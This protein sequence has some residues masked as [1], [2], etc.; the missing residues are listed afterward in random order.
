MNCIRLYP[1]EPATAGYPNSEIEVGVELSYMWK[2]PRCTWN[3]FLGSS[4]L[5][6]GVN[7]IFKENGPSQVNQRTNSNPT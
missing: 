5:D 1:H 4:Y 2:M 6:T 7:C 3:K